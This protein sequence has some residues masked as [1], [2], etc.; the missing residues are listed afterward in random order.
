MV[1]IRIAAKDDIE[2][3]CFSQVLT[4]IMK[5][6]KNLEQIKLRILKMWKK[7]ILYYIIHL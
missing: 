7:D 4:K 3:L 1:E 5:I 2:D 6:L